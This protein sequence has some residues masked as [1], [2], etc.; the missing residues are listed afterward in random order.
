MN[1]F[2]YILIILFC[3]AESYNAHLIDAAYE[4]VKIAWSQ[5]VIFQMATI[6]VAGAISNGSRRHKS[7]LSAVALFIAWQALTDWTPVFPAW[8]S[9]WETEAFFG[10][11]VWLMRRSMRI[12]SYSGSNVSLAF[13]TP[14]QSRRPSTVR[15]FI[16]R[17]VGFVQS[18]F[19]LPYEGV[20]LVVNGQAMIPR[21]NTG[22]F[23][24]VDLKV[25]SRWWTILG[26][27]SETTPEIKSFF[28]GIEGTPVSM[29]NCVHAIK[30]VL[31]ILGYRSNTP[32][33][34]A[35]EVLN[36]G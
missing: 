15:V 31:A 27:H 35:M 29:A 7:I 16:G 12:P 4:Y 28:D 24:R 25:I 23:V 11:V 10:L 9:S 13:F 17:L 6:A 22:T 20:A 5:L 33:T 30:P 14:P 18:L 34:L 3:A 26:T 19:G 8:L 21:R 32:G 1:R 2:F 36:G